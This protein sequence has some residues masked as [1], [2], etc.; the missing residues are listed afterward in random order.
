MANYYLTKLF[1]KYKS[2]LDKIN[3]KYTPAELFMHC[4]KH[5]SPE[6]TLKCLISMNSK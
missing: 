3:Y 5:T 6:N 2:D 1:D 4:S